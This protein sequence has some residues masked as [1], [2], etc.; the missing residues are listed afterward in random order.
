VRSKCL[1]QEHVSSQL[2][3]TDPVIHYFSHRPSA[4]RE[5]HGYG[6]QRES[7]DRRL[8]RNLFDRVEAHKVITDI[9][10]ADKAKSKNLLSL[11]QVI[12]SK[13][14]APVY[15]QICEEKRELKPAQLVGVQRLSWVVGEFQAAVN[16]KKPEKQHGLSLRARP[17][18]QKEAQLFD[19]AEKILRSMEKQIGQAQTMLATKSREALKDERVEEIFYLL[20]MNKEG[21]CQVALE[22]F[23]DLFRAMLASNSADDRLTAF[24]SAS[25]KAKN[26][27]LLCDKEGECGMLEF[28]SGV[29]AGTKKLSG[30]LGDILDSVVKK[31]GYK[32]KPKGVRAAHFVMVNA[33]ESR[34]ES[35]GPKEPAALGSKPVDSKIATTGEI[36]FTWYIHWEVLYIVDVFASSFCGEAGYELSTL[37]SKLDA[38]EELA[39]CVVGHSIFQWYQYHARCHETFQ[40]P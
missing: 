8:E 36:N 30:P 40:G 4:I 39:R 12:S 9:D 29:S 13:I 10:T 19:K 25:E 33:K 15:K 17:R 2:R 11:V 32:T 35:D 24:Y 27:I 16:Q 7:F 14:W 28:A 5:K 23:E 37:C 34:L 6:W 3:L 1:S 26:A 18:K 38:N 21:C 20:A 22:L 31:L